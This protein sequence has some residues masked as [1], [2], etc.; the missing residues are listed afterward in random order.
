MIKKRL[1]CNHYITIDI[2]IEAGEIVEVKRDYGSESLVS[3]PKCTG[4]FAW[5]DVLEDVEVKQ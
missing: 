3:H 4:F 1:L 2:T 5:N